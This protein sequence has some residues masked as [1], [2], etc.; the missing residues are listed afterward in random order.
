MAQNIITVEALSP[1]A[2]AHS[3]AALDHETRAVVVATE[4]GQPWARVDIAPMTDTRRAVFPLDSHG[5]RGD[6]R[7]PSCSGVMVTKGNP[8]ALFVVIERARR[9][10]N[11]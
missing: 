2:F 1:A 4:N 9:M 5:V 3:L 11:A 8:Q 7:K 6:T 10:H